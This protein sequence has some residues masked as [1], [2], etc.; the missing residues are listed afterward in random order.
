MVVPILLLTGGYMLRWVFV[1]AG[2][3]TFFR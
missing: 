2:Q 3:D 1:H